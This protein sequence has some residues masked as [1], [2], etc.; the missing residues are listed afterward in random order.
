MKQRTK[1]ILLGAGLGI[2]TLYYGFTIYGLLISAGIYHVYA[3][4]LFLYLSIGGILGIVGLWMLLLKEKI[5]GI[6]KFFTIILLSIG[7]IS[8]LTVSFL[9]VEYIKYLGL[10]F[11]ASLCIGLP[12][13]TA[14]TVF[15]MY[16]KMYKK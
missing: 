6:F 2:V 8:A 14:I 1:D 7:I 9:S 13:L 16:F 10:Y 11:I 5:H 4:Y 12:I 15:G 3:N